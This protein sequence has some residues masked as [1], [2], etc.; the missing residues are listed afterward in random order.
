MIL[1]LAS[2]TGLQAPAAR[3]AATRDV[4]LV[5]LAIIRLLSTI[6]GA[7]PPHSSSQV[8]N[9]FCAPG[10]AKMMLPRTTTPGLLPCTRT[11]ATASP[12]VEH[13]ALVS[14]T[15][16]GESLSSTE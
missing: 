15:A 16:L 4:T 7:W 12:V 6:Q 3:T 2:I 8:A 9:E 11:P 10:P 5:P 1:L 14:T 13:S